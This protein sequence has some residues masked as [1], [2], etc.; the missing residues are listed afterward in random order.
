MIFYGMQIPSHLQNHR[1]ARLQ[2]RE[3]LCGLQGLEFGAMSVTPIG[4][5]SSG[6]LGV[7][8]IVTDADGD[9]DPHDDFMLRFIAI[10]V[11]PWQ[12]S[13]LLVIR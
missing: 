12:R 10:Q 1:D 2:L 7:L 13:L 9:L 11:N 6:I 5:L 8:Q 4:T 3:D